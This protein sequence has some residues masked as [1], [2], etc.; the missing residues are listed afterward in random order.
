M[1]SVTYQAWL[2]DLDG[3]LYY[4]TALQLAMALELA[5]AGRSAIPFIHAFREE[6]ERM[7]RETTEPLADPY[8]LQI[9]RTAARLGRPAEDVRGVV[10]QWMIARPCRWLRP[11]RRRGLLQEV[12]DFRKRG[13]KTAVVSDYPA[14]A[15]LEAMRIAHLFDVVIASGESPEPLRL[16]PWPG[17]YLRAAAT[18]RVQPQD[19]LVI[20]DRV[21][22]DGQAA[23]RAGMAFRRV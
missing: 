16:K 13:G 11:F 8:R 20:G 18:L 2:V 5:L 1:A 17:G 3:T 21:D 15:K 4:Q 22:A 10:A 23:R 19:C 7:R 9:E 14:Q 12:W 6:H